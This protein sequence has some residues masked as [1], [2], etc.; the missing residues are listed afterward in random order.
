MN[1]IGDTWEAIRA[2]QRE[3]KRACVVAAP[4]I[5]EAAGLKFE[6]FDSE[7]QHIRVE[8]IYDFWPSTGLFMRRG[9]NKRMHSIEK[10]INVIKGKPV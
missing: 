9:S 10:L 3:E 2:K 1:E 4:G 8:N 5:L 6:V 7:G